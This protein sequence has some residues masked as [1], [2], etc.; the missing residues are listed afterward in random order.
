MKINVVK[1][2]IPI[3][4]AG[5]ILVYGVSKIGKINEYKNVSSNDIVTTTNNT[6]ENNIPENNVV[7]ENNKVEENTNTLPN[8]T[9][10]EEVVEEPTIETINGLNM[11]IKK[12]VIPTTTVNVRKDSSTDSDILGT[13]STNS[14]LDLIN[15]E[16]AEWY[17]VKY[18]DEDAYISKKYST[19]KEE[20]TI[21]DPML[22]IICFKDSSTMYDSLE[23][24]NTIMSIPYLEAAEVYKEFDNNY[25]ISLDGNIGYVSKQNTEVLDDTFVIVDISDQTAHLYEGNELIVSTNVVTGK[26]SSPTTKGLHEVWDIETNRYL[27]GPG[28]NVYVDYVMFFHN[29]EG[30][31][32]S[33]YHTH[34]NSNGKVAF[35]HGWR[36]SSAYG[37]DIYKTNG[38]HGCVNMP[39]EPTKTMYE[40]L[41]LG[42]KV[43]VKE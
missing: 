41:K 17:K 16:N 13:I 30:L 33:E 10:E 15:Q 26:P 9:K 24:G 40:H 8:T 35:S 43:L 12:V 37:R 31:H 42:D 4:V 3:I 32:D 39:Y 34:Y 20:K 14:Q 29:G 6:V 1:K 36:S 22:K 7:E 19:I 25:L 27:K 23:N 2:A 38:S 5:T 28:Y 21:K 11:E 18:K